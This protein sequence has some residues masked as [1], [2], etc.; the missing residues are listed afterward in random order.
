MRRGGDLEREVPE[1][2][3]LFAL[4]FGGRGLGSSATLRRGLRDFRLYRLRLHRHLRQFANIKSGKTIGRVHELRGV[5]PGDDGK[6]FKVVSDFAVARFRS[7]GFR[8]FRARLFRL[9]FGRRVYGFFF[10]RRVN[11][12]D[13]L[14]DLV[15]SAIFFLLC[16]VRR[17]YF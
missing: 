3:L 16:H 2:L 10:V 11:E 9:L 4:F 14:G 13:R 17:V 8:V 15:L 7:L 6:A 12:V 5:Q 1:G